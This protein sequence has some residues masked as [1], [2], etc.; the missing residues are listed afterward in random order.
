MANRATFPPSPRARRT[1]F[2]VPIQSNVLVPRFFE[3]CS[4]ATGSATVK[5]PCTVRAKQGRVEEEAKATKGVKGERG[6]ENVKIKGIRSGTSSIH[7]RSPVRYS[8]AQRPFVRRIKKRWREGGRGE[9]RD[10]TVGGCA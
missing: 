5:S 9:G 3:L 1:I 7:H 2:F 10:A 4:A 8:P 6:D